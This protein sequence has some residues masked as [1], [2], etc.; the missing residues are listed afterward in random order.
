M[1]RKEREIPKAKT[2]SIFDL[3]EMFPNEQAAID[4]IAQI[5]WKD[6]VV[7]PYCQSDSQRFDITCQKRRNCN[8]NKALRHV[9]IGLF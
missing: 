6:G 4:H 7:C 1:A 8:K 5:L 2:L 3:Q 9:G